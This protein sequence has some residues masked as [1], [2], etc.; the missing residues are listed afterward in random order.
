WSWW[1]GKRAA[2]SAAGTARTLVSSPSLE[3]SPRPPVSDR[4]GEERARRLGSAGCAAPD[5]A[6]LGRADDVHAR[7]GE[8]GEGG[9]RLRREVDRARHDDRRRAVLEQVQARGQV[10][11]KPEQVLDRPG[12]AVGLCLPRD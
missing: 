12:D 5:A 9:V 7:V 2:K 1:T 8:A 6:W 3:R 4:A 11:R 10:R